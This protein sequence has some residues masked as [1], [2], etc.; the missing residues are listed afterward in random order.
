VFAARPRHLF[1][2]VSDA[3]APRLQLR[4]TITVSDVEF[5]ASPVGSAGSAIA[6]PSP[7]LREIGR[8]AVNWRAR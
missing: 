3:P 1:L 6:V 7:S 5:A 4:D 2:L 8:G